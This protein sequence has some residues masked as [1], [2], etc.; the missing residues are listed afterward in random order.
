MSI[1]SSLYDIMGLEKVMISMCEYLLS[2]L[3]YQ[4]ETEHVRQM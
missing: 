1:S 2:K 4:Q 3:D